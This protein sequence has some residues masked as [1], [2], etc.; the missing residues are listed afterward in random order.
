MKITKIAKTFSLMAALSTLFVLP[1]AAEPWIKAESQHFIVYSDTTEAET[2]D[3]IAKLEAFDALTDKLYRQIGDSEL[4]DYRKT[5]FHYLKEFNDFKVLGAVNQNTAAPVM[6]CAYDDPQLFSVHTAKISSKEDIGY[7]DLG[8][9]YLFY[10][11]AHVKTVKYFSYRLP[12][13]VDGG[14]AEYFSTVNFQADKIIVGQPMPDL[15]HTTNGHKLTK[16]DL[17]PF[18]DIVSGRTSGGRDP[19]AYRFQTWLMISY[20]MSDPVRKTGFLDY[21]D[22]VSQ[23]DDGLAA[24]TAETGM[25]PTDFDAVFAEYMTKGS[26][27]FTYPAPA[28]IAADVTV[29]PVVDNYEPLPVVAAGVHTCTGGK[30]GQALLQSARQIANRYPDD[31]LAQ[32]TL[33]GADINFGDPTTDVPGAAVPI[34]QA[35]LKANPN[36]WEAQ[37]WLGRY[38]LLMA[39][40]GPAAESDANYALARQ[41]LGKAYK[42]D[43]TSAPILYFYVEAHRNLPDFPD[44]NTVQALDLAQSYSR[45][46]YDVLEA[47][48]DARRG[49]MDA[50]S[51]MMAIECQYCRSDDAWW[52]PYKAIKDALASHQSKDDILALFRAYDALAPRTTGR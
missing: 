46:A 1:A 49:D 6:G 43:P 48:L 2:R 9:S 28:A 21:L 32:I 41:E 11:Y 45:S 40:R 10:A 33:A 20:F 50:A 17:A 16:R 8:L 36:D 22:K 29:T 47:E 42:L 15:L 7:V 5:V 3:Y 52:K 37:Q 27:Q 24:F 19:N 38:Y 26:P 39:R 35:H 12:A 30:Y 51:A 44:D 13:W 4:P 18:E 23:G 34:L 25:K 14:L 31:A